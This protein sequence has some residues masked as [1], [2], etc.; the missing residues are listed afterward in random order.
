MPELETLKLTIISLRFVRD[1]N[2]VTALRTAK[3][4][5][6]D[7][8]STVNKYKTLQAA[9][10][11]SISA[12]SVTPEIRES[13]PIMPPEVNRDSEGPLDRVRSESGI[14]SLQERAK[15]VIEC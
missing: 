6:N 12:A 14:I 2:S 11:A 3:G 10:W 1:I 7:S 5:V 8:V 15:G 4:P 13:V 9:P